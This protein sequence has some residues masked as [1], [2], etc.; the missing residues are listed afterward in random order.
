M[1]KV[2]VIYLQGTEESLLREANV[3]LDIGNQNSESEVNTVLS[4]YKSEGNPE[5]YAEAYTDLKKFVEGA[6]DTYKVSFSLHEA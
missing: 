2:C 5:F 1:F 4:A 6:L 3:N